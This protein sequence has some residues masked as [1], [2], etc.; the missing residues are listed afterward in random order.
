MTAA[1][2]ASSAH[3]VVMNINI[4]ATTAAATEPAANRQQSQMH[5]YAKFHKTTACALLE[6][7]KANAPPGNS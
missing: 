6:P 7:F 2:V 5:A 3:V 1:I 4:T